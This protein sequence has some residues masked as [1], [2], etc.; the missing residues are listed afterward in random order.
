MT[1]RRKTRSDKGGTHRKPPPRRPYAEQ[2]TRPATALLRDLARKAYARL[3]SYRKAGAAIGCSGER[4]RQLL[5]DDR[6]N[7]VAD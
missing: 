3:G 4:V 1:E 5:T 7:N 2:A 6:K